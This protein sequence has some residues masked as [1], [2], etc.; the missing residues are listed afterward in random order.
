MRYDFGTPTYEEDFSL[1][2]QV[3]LRNDTYQY[4]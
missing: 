1:N 4:L 3:V 2:G